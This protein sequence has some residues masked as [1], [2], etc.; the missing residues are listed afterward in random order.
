MIWKRLHP[1]TPKQE[2]EFAARMTEEKVPFADKLIMMLTGFAVVVVP[3]LLVLIGL[4][5]L[6]MWIFRML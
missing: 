1:S 3:S 2:S 6:V 5:L 4:S